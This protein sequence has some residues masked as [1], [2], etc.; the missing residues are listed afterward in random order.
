MKISG[1]GFTGVASITI[2]NVAFYLTQSNSTMQYDSLTVTT[3]PNTGDYNITVAL[4]DIPVS[5]LSDSKYTFGS[6]FT[7]SVS[8]VSPTT[9]SGPIDLIIVGTGFGNGNNLAAY[10]IKVGNQSCVATNVT[11]TQIECHL[12]GV[13][14]GAQS[15]SVNID[16]NI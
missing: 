6:E 9:A 5:W 11:D 4:D 13:D 8:S 14:V 15:V 12:D 2:G 3:M 7:P 16:G 1:D 10:E